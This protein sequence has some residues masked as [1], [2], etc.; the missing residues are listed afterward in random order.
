M[1]DQTEEEPL[2]PQVEAIRQKMMRL[3]LISGGIMMIGLM[4]V[5]LAIVYKVTQGS[6]AIPVVPAEAELKLPADARIVSAASDGDRLTVTI[7][8][9]DGT[10]EIRIYA[11]DASLRTRYTVVD[12]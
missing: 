10:N 11:A 8:L 9:P 12:E 3:L 4:A 6:Q 2:D 5:L 7:R 1:I